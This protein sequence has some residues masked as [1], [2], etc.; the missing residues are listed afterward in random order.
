MNFD[1]E[2]SIVMKSVGHAESSLLDSQ[3]ESIRLFTKM[4]FVFVFIHTTELLRF[5]NVSC[6]VNVDR[7]ARYT[8]IIVA[9]LVVD[10]VI[11]VGLIFIN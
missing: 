2:L 8:K 5:T 11:P 10:F 6:N 1:T 3:I 7:Y 4:R 9:F